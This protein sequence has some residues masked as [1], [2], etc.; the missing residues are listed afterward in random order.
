MITVIQ[1]LRNSIEQQKGKRLQLQKSIE[2]LKSSLTGNRKNLHRH[3]QA[4][5]IVRHVGLSTQEQL[6]FHISGLVTLALR[7]VFEDDAYE[8]KVEFVQRRGKTEC[9]LSFVRDKEQID[10]LAASGGGVVDVAAFALRAASWSMECPR[11]RPVLI[12]DEP[13]RYLSTDLLPKASLMLREISQRLGLQ[14]IMVTHSEE[15]TEDANKVFRVMKRKG[16]SVVDGESK[17]TN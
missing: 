9:D 11:S 6:Q 15:L 5:E 3:E 14:L 16:I 2:S 12:L 8:F 17:H 7:A 1:A 4:L 13:F 10:P